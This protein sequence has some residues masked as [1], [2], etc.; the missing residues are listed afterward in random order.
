MAKP[1]WIPGGR[2][3]GSHIKVTGPEL[4]GLKMRS[5]YLLGC[6]F[7]LLAF[8]ALRVEKKEEIYDRYFL[9]PSIEEKVQQNQPN[10]LCKSRI[11]EAMFDF[12]TS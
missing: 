5:W 8:V 9:K 6:S 11:W 1:T 3:R 4:V 10:N 2:E 7:S 12:G